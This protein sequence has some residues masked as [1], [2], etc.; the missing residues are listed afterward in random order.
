MNYNNNSLIIS[1]AENRQRVSVEHSWLAGNFNLSLISASCL[2]MTHSCQVQIVMEGKEARSLEDRDWGLWSG[3]H[4]T[5]MPYRDAHLASLGSF[6]VPLGEGEIS[7]ERQSLS[8]PEPLGP[9]S[10]RA[11]WKE[12]EVLIGLISPNR[13]QLLQDLNEH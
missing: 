4:N 2:V 12:A 11:S 8:S 1:S 5:D 10:F 9:E 3:C 13:S 7:P 6:S